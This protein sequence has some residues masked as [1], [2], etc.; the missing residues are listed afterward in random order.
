VNKSLVFYKDN[1]VSPAKDAKQT[2]INSPR[3]RFCSREKSPPLR[4]A[5]AGHGQRTTNLRKIAP[6]V[7]R[8]MQADNFGH[9]ADQKSKIEK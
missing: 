9:A 5:G 4:R 8:Q 1:R 2:P 7:N 6:R 3:D